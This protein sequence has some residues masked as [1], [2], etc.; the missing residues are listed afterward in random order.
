VLFDIGHGG[1]GFGFKTTRAMLAAGF[2]PT[3]SPATS[4]DLDPRAGLRPAG[5]AV[6]VRLP[7]RAAGRGHPPRHPD[8]R[9]AVQRPEL[10]K[11]VEGGIGDASVLELA[12]GDW[13]YRD[14][15]GERLEG[16]QRLLAR[17]MVA[18]GRWFDPAAQPTIN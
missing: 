15:L 5:D 17:G 2:L 11:L 12:D 10:G 1:G 7:R 6:E 8:R 3:S 4:T 18:G 9:R 14:V 13:S 16:K